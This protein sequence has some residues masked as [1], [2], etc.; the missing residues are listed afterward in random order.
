MRSKAVLSIIAFLAAFGIS[1][2][3]TPRTSTKSTAG[4]PYV[5]RSCAQ[6]AAAR[7]I[8]SLLEQDIENGNI[9]DRKMRR[10]RENGLSRNSEEYFVTYARLT[11]QYVTASQAI[12]DSQLP[13]DFTSAWRAHM[14]AWRNHADFLNETGYNPPRSSVDGAGSGPRE[15]YAQQNNEI[16]NTWFEVLRVAREYD[17]YIPPDAY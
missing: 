3:V 17:A 11:D 2:A 6:T 16:S 7:R 12:D 13:K 14:K 15:T 5:K 9:L 4:N 10:V 1:V 8:T